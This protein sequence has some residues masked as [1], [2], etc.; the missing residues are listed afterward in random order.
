MSGSTAVADAFGPY[1]PLMSTRLS[2]PVR[3]SAGES[4]SS[5]RIRTLGLICA[6]GGLLGAASVVPMLAVPPMV[7]PDRF[8]YPF[9]AGWHIVAEVFFALQ[10]RSGPA[11]QEHDTSQATARGP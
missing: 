5:G 9:S 1:G 3:R 11:Q 2:T 6:I 10:H 4:R 7:G 8:S